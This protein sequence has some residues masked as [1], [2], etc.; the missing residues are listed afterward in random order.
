MFDSHK[1]EFQDGTQLIIKQDKNNKNTL[2]I[3]LVFCNA[4]IIPVAANHFQ[5]VKINKAVP[6]RTTKKLKEAGVIDE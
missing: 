5:I 4:A 6:E 1:I 3:Y 2:D